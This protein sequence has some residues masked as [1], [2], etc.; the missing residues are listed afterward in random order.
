MSAAPIGF[1]GK[2]P[3]HGDFIQRRVPEAFVNAW[4]AWLQHCMVASRERL[5]EQ[6]LQIYLTSPVW[7]FVLAEGV[8]GSASY[9][10]VLIP[11]VDRVGRYFP[12]TVVAELPA[13]VAPL[14]AT[15]HGRSWFGSIES[16]ALAALD[17]QNFELERFDAALCETTA[18]LALMARTAGSVIDETFPLSSHHWRMPIES[19][20]K[21]AA[22]LIDTLMAPVSRALRPLSMWWTA[23]SEHVGAS[24]LLARG[25]PDPQRFTAMLDGSWQAS[26]WS[27]EPA[28]LVRDVSEPFQYHTAS[29]ALTDV[30]LVRKQ[31]EDA[32]FECADLGLWAVADGMGGHSH[33]AEASQMV[34]D[35][36]ASLE[37]AATLS[38]ALTQGRIALE[39]VNADLQ[40]AAL[41]VNDKASSGSTVVLL[42]VQQHEWGVLWAGD[43]RVYLLRDG[44]LNAL[45]RDHS[46]DQGEQH[47]VG[48]EMGV[49]R[50][51]SGV[52]T[53]AVGG[54]P[55]LVLDQSSGVLQ[56]GDRFL[57]CSDGLHG[58]VPHAEIHSIL[59]RETDPSAAVATLITAAKNARSRDNIT[60]VVVDVVPET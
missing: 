28:D 11:S 6:W 3:S 43:S 15:I 46:E 38:A 9:A 54:H 58:A 1:H 36:L 5:G 10:G 47:V 4:D 29:A 48:G 14:A 32:F 44:A 37:P 22:A 57:L 2:L 24:C 42:S 7:R 12:F 17:A 23:G 49:P 34:V 33:G 51:C 55:Q 26:G 31:N 18:E 30:G 56:P 27:G 25:L 40:R 19:P 16:L 50:V 53:R 41:R 60:A 8:A 59:Q 13:D 35:A 20:E 52:I 21:V 45:T 39:R